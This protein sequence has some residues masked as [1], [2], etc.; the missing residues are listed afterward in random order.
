MR[1]G[2]EWAPS[3]LGIVLCA[4][5]LYCVMLMTEHICNLNFSVGAVGIL[6]RTVLSCAGLIIPVL[7]RGILMC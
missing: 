4:Y 3:E 2:R 7:L 6:G 1:W 5:F